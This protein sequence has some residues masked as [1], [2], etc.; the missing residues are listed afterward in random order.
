MNNKT[1][2]VSLS[3]L[4]NIKHGYAFKGEN[5]VANK[6]IYQLVT[7]GN[8]AIGGGFQIKKEKFYDGPIPEEYVLK[9]NDLVVTMT[10][11]SKEGDTLGYSA[12]IPDTKDTIWLHNQR[13]GLISIKKTADVD[14]IFLSYLMRTQNYRAHVLSGLTGSTVKHTSPSK[15]CEY[16][17]NLPSI[18]IQKKIASILKN[19]DSKI[20]L[21]NKT[22]KT[23]ESIA[24]S[25]FKSWF[26]DFDP[27]HAKQQV[28]KC[29][30]IDKATADLFPSSF[31]ESELGLIPKDW[32]VTSIKDICEVITNGGTPSRSNS[33]FWENGTIPWYK[34]G[35]LTDSFLI[36]HSESITQLGLEK[37]SVKLMDKE[38]VLMA[39]YAAPTV[40]RLGIL[41]QASTFNQATTGMKA[42]QEIGFV[43]L[44]LTLLFGR[45]WFNNRANGAAQQNISKAI[46]ESYKLILPSTHILTSFNNYLMPMFKR[47]EQNINQVSTLSNL[48]DTLLPRLISGKLDLSNIEEHLEEVA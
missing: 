2:L 23:L 45:D 18:S 34:T 21:L 11:L 31:V 28:K 35:E 14:L 43:F 48:R 41:T 39:I 12:L 46:V 8:F 13:V 5:F 3:D 36:N 32:A 9:E 24:Q 16:K 27:V 44:Y 1:L 17:F 26:I 10:D 22:N 38:C 6:S 4:I 7:P 20:E 30:G 19:L 15:I 47:I 42:K 25:I 33:L 37:S 29:A 40:G